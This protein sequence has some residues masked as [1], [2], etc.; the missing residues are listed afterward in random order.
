MAGWRQALPQRVR[1][2]Q[3][4]AA[5]KSPQRLPFFSRP[6]RSGGR[7]EPAARPFKLLARALM[8]LS[9]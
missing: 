7:V 4:G 5:R 2:P 6:R 1:A 8:K 9:M 3:R